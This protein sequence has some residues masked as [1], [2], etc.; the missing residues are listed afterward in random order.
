MVTVSIFCCKTQRTKYKLP[1]PV[2]AFLA[3]LGRS[4]MISTYY[5]MYKTTNNGELTYAAAQNVLRLNKNHQL[6]YCIRC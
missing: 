1:R 4:R 2:F 6:D 5:I 3:L